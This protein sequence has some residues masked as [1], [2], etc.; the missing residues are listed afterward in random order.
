MI[1]EEKKGNMGRDEIHGDQFPIGMRVL[2]VDDDPICLKVLETLL[3]RCQYHVTTTNQA[4]QALNMLRENKDKFDLV[5]SDVHMPDMDGFKLL[6]HV[7]LEMD[8]PVI[9][10]D[11]EKVQ[12]ENSDGTQAAGVNGQLDRMAKVNKKRKDQNDDDEDDCE[13]NIHD[14]EDPHPRKS[15]GLFGPLNST[16]SLLRLSTNWELIDYDNGM[17]CGSKKYRLYLKRLS[18]VASQ[19]PNMAAVLGG[20][21]ASYLHMG[22]FNGYGSYHGLSSSG[23]LQGLTTFPPNGVSGRTNSSLLGLP[24]ITQELNNRFPGGVCVASNNTL[25]S[26]TNNSLL[27]QGHQQQPQLRGLSNP[28]SVAIPSIV[29]DCHEMSAGVSANLPDLSRFNETLQTAP[30]LSGYHTNSMSTGIPNNNGNISASNMGTRL[31][32]TALQMNGKQ[33]NISSNNVPVAAQDSVTGRSMQCPTSS[34]SGNALLIPSGINIDPKYFNFG[35]AGDNK[36][37]SEGP[38]QQSALNPNFAYGSTLNSTFPNQNLL[39]TVSDCQNRIQDKRVHASLM[40]QSTSGTPFLR[41]FK[42]DKSIS[43]NRLPFNEDSTLGTSR[44]QAGFVSNDCNF[45]ELMN[46]MIKPERDGIGFVD[47]EIGSDIFPLSTCMRHK[48]DQIT[49]AK[50]AKSPNATM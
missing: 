42:I 49:A 11:H 25:A 20:R 7:G 12:T 13:E 50:V 24:G 38:K 21:D 9:R 14:N 32:Q 30:T 26:V 10:E 5:I 18:A 47:G 17:R 34:F 16:A 19:Q 36:Q 27:L 4:I 35:I 39:D 41:S 43:D 33:L 48:V 45:D 1:V 44:V 46:A 23:Q 6:E 2:A 22:S 3:L 29:S 28:P 8:L 31:A 37:I 15:Q 40:N